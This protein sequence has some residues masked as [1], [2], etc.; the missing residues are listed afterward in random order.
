MISE[1]KREQLKQSYERRIARGEK[2]GFQKGHKIFR[3]KV[4][5]D[6]MRRRI[7]TFKRNY[8]YKSYPKCKVCQVELKERRSTHCLK[9]VDKSYCKGKISPNKGKHWKLNLT[10]EQ[11]A[12]RKEIGK[13]KVMSESARQKIREW[14]ILHPNRIFRNTGIE[15]AIQ[16]EL[17]DRKII[18]VKQIGIEDVAT[19][20]FFL[21]DFNIVIQCDGCYWHNCLEHYP[22]HHKEQRQKDMTQ[23]AKFLARGIKVY[24]FWEHDIK[25]SPKDCLNFISEL[26]II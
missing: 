9:H 24:R 4:T 18:F 10:P 17:A 23:N 3:G 2:F 13:T 1:K 16:D 11:K 15:L 8:I 26:K 19:V 6:E 5:K 22:N 25:R 14:H 21:P 12:R 7:E 20:D